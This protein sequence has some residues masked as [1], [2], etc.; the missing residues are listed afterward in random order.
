MSRGRVAG[1][2]VAVAAGAPCVSRASVRALEGL[3]LEGDRYALG[4][5]EYSARPGTGRHVTLVDRAAVAAA[6]LA[7]GESRRNIETDGVDLA[8]LVGMRFRIGTAELVGM[9][10][11][12]PCGYLQRLVGRPIM[13]AL[14]GRGGLRAEVV[15]SGVVSVGDAVT[16]LGRVLIVTED[17]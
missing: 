5:G 12:P 13:A 14:H 2:H 4:I 7:P 11:C 17:A 8:A 15:V 3:G 1:I 6:G 9:R 16:V 10:E